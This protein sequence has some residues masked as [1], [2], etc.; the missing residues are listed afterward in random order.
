M[1]QLG[2][3]LIGRAAASIF[4]L[5]WW[6]FWAARFQRM[7]IAHPEKLTSGAARDYRNRSGRYTIALLSLSPKLTILCD[8]VA[9]LIVTELALVL[10][11]FGGCVCWTV[12]VPGCNRTN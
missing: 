3:V 4:G 5:M 8:W 2:D 7:D 10:T 12:Y 9:R 1:G 11:W 6:P